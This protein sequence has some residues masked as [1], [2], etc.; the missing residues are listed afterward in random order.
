MGELRVVSLMS[1]VLVIA[2][3]FGDF[4]YGFELW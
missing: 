1:E 2:W 3:I 4:G